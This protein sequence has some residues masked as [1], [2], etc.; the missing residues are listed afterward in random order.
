MALLTST[1]ST[2]HGTVL[3]AAQA[4]SA[5]DTFSNANGRTLI[6][7]NNGSGSTVTVTLVTFGTYPVSSAVT[8]DV[9]DDAQTVAA[10]VSKVFGPFNKA[11][12]NGATDLITVTFSATTSITAR[13]IELG[14]A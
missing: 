7:V 14:T 10:G 8:Y 11:L 3:P 1:T 12:M 13:V 4:V 5:S 6:E 9:A 2:A